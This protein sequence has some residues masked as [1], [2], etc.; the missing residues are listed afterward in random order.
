[1][2]LMRWQHDGPIQ[3]ENIVLLT[4]QEAK[5]HEKVQNVLESYPE[6]ACEK[7]SD[8]LRDCAERSR[9][10]EA[11]EETDTTACVE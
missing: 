3:K 10:K 2:R 8:A 9:A 11:K 6:D 4:E 1:M 5:A 7:I